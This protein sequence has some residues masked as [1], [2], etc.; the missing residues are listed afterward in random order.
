MSAEHLVDAACVDA[1]GSSGY[2]TISERTGSIVRY[3]GRAAFAARLR[4]DSAAKAELIRTLNL[5]VD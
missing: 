4:E 1:A 2:R 3:L 5:K